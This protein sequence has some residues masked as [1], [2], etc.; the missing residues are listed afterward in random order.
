MWPP[1]SSETSQ[2]LAMQTA[3]SAS[4]RGI[5][6]GVTAVGNEMILMTDVAV[7]NAGTGLAL[8]GTETMTGTAIG[9]GDVNATVMAS[10][11]AATACLITPPM[12]PF[13]TKF[14]I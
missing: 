8:I 3:E 5:G 14:I 2:T 6:T 9:I 12:A 11:T 13:S 10:D 7:A 1:R 4:A